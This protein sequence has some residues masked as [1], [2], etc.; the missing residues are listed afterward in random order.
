MFG[1]AH[2]EHCL[3]SSSINVMP[4]IGCGGM[5]WHGHL[6]AAPG[7]ALAL[8]HLPGERLSVLGEGFEIPSSRSTLSGKRFFCSLPRKR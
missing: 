7:K 2:R 6:H 1:T 8:L 5:A 4:F 3:I